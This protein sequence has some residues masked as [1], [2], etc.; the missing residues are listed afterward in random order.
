MTKYNFEPLDCSQ[1]PRA[2]THVTFGHDSITLGGLVIAALGAPEHVTVFYD[3]SSRMLGFR[4][5]RNG[6]TGTLRVSKSGQVPNGSICTATSWRPEK[7]IRFEPEWIDGMAVI[8]PLP[9]A[10]S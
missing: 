6:A 10:D 3:R 7:R 2:T 9:E 1:H 5:A 8:G 4:A